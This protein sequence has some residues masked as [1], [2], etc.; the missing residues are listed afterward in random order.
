[1]FC[2]GLLLLQGP[3]NGSTANASAPGDDLPGRQVA[4]AGR[5]WF[6]QDD[7]TA[8]PQ[9]EETVTPDETGQPTEE[10]ETGPT[11]T[12]TY[13]PFPSITI[14][15]TR[16]TPTDVLMSLEYLPGATAMPKASPWNGARLLRWWPLAVLLAFWL[17]LVIWFVVAQVAIEITR[18][19][20]D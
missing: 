8:T 2:V 11:L 9:V 4:D 6:L 14:Q 5:G 16:V 17:V 7:V 19:R 15:Y 13:I 1:M 10:V 20:E 3:V 18:R 12:P